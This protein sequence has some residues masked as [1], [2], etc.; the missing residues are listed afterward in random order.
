MIEI[1]YGLL[2]KVVYLNGATLKFESGVVRDIRVIPTGISKNEAGEDVL[3]GYDVLYQL[4][5][6]IVLTSRE[7]Y[8]SEE[9]AKEALRQAL[10]AE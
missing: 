4:Q 10:F 5:S 1:K 7:V 3:D 6:G 9:Q 8:D 2:E